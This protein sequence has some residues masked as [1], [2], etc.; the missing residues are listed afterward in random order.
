MSTIVTCFDDENGVDKIS[1]ELKPL[2][3]VV[4]SISVENLVL[5]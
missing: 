3:V 1:V 5:V 4:V 2:F